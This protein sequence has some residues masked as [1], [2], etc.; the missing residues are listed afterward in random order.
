MTLEQINDKR[1][2]DL[3]VLE[4]AEKIR[5]LL[6]KGAKTYESAGGE[7]DFEAEVLEL[8]AEAP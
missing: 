1:A 6:D 2:R 4:T 7:E 8:V 5:E 3:A